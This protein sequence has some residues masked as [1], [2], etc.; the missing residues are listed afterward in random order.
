[1]NSP[2]RRILRTLLIALGC[3][4]LT[5]NATLAADKGML[6][7]ST[8]PGEAEIYIN[9]K[10]KGKSPAEVGQTFAIQLDE[11][12]YTV[13]AM[14]P[15]G[16]KEHFA[17]KKI[18]I[19]DG[20]VQPV[21][22]KLAEHE[23][24]AA[25]TANELKQKY[26]NYMPDPE[27]VAIKS[28]KFRMG[29]LES[30]KICINNK[31][32]VL[33]MNVPGF[34]IGKYA[35]I[36]DMWDA[37]YAQGGCDHYPDD[38]GWG[39]GKRPVIN[40]S[41]NDIQKFLA[42]INRK[43]GKTYRLPTETEWEYAARA[44]TST[45]YSWGDEIGQKNANCKGCGSQWDN[46][47]TAPVGSFAANPWGLYDMHGNVWQ[48][49]SGCYVQYKDMTKYTDALDWKDSKSG[50]CESEKRVLRGGSWN[51]SPEGLRAA[52]SRSFL[53]W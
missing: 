47:Q 33:D 37:C 1:M 4:V 23:S 34:E 25:M 46:K 7:I 53:P 6:R 12:E 41:L 48:W 39:R 35:V 13:K 22:L 44:G 50:T 52:Y 21:V 15:N 36:F 3:A 11:G 32:P 31:N 42:W 29:C 9:D 43:T 27:M 14:K 30:D 28:G 18:F 38:K 51:N 8:E 10:C 24:E 40:V 16:L 19:A 49:V 5:A 2:R 17:E 20:T 45:V 26:A